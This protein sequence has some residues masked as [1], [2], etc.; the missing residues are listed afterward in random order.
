M[1]ILW[2]RRFFFC[3]KFFESKYIGRVLQQKNYFRSFVWISKTFITYSLFIRYG[4]TKSITVGANDLK[5]DS[6]T[7]KLPKRLKRYSL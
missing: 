7:T 3:S 4:L 6:E 5:S 2:T 1:R